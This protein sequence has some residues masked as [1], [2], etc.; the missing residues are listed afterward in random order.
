MRK[1]FRKIFDYGERIPNDDRAISQRRTFFRRGVAQ[2]LCAR[3]FFRQGNRDLLKR[4]L[5]ITHQDPRPEGPGRIGFV[6]DDEG[7]IH[8]RSRKDRRSERWICGALP[9]GSAKIKLL[10]GI[11]TY[12]APK[13]AE[14]FVV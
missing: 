2:Y 1:S 4:N 7:K 5:K 10:C 13:R 6:G 9:D 12:E 14:F 11:S 3:V 8:K